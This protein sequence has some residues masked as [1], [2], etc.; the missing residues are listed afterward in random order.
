MQTKHTTKTN[1]R[2]RHYP[3]FFEVITVIVF[4]F[5]V[6]LLGYILAAGLLAGPSVN[7]AQAYALQTQRVLNVTPT[8][9]PFQPVADAD[10]PSIPNN[11]IPDQNLNSTDADEDEPEVSVT[12]SPTMPTLKKP[13]GQ[14]NILLL[15]SDVRPN[16]GGFRTDSIIWVSLNPKDGFVSAVSFPRDLYVNIP[17]MSYNRINVAFPRGGFDLLADTF[18]SNFGVRP[19]H[20]VLIDFNGFKTII[21]NLGGIN[22]YAEKNLSDSCAD[23]I[24]PSGYCSVGPGMVHMNGELALWYARSRYSSNDIERARRA[25]EVI[26]AMFKRLMSLDAILR[27][28]ELYNAYIDYVQTDLALSDLLPLLP[29]ASKINENGDIRNYV[30]GFDHAYSWITA[31]GA[32]V[33]VPDNEA[34]T[35]VLIEALELEYK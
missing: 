12:P 1:R 9:T 6:C 25:Q 26:E 10:I 29:L 17:E 4:I 32:Q 19:D 24:D 31:Q 5:L 11:P 7:P 14:V 27:A 23:W 34:I 30:I 22:V 20:Y 13:S 28:P 8:A 16:D 2:R 3:K 15:G 18:E 35:Q 33:L 21:N